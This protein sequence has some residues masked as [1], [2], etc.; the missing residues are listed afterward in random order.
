MRPVEVVWPASFPDA[1]PLIIELGSESSELA[2]FRFEDRSLCLFA[3][4]VHPR[5]W[6]PEL[7]VADALSRYVE[8]RARISSGELHPLD[9]PRPLPGHPAG[10][11]IRIPKALAR[12][13]RE[14][15]GW[16]L[17]RGVLR[18][19]RESL[20]VIALRH[21]GA[22][23]AP[24]IAHNSRPWLE[25]VGDGQPMDFAWCGIKR[26]DNEAWADLFQDRASLMALLERRCPPHIAAALRKSPFMILCNTKKKNDLII[27][28]AD[29]G[30][31]AFFGLFTSSIEVGDLSDRVFARV[32]GALSG[33]R[34]LSTA[35]VICVG[36]G[37]LG[38]PVAVQL[39]RA[40]V[41][42]FSLFDPERLSPENV[43]RHVGGLRDLDRPKVEVVRDA[44]LQRHAD[45][46]VHIHAS[47]LTWD[48]DDM[49]STGP[50]FREALADPGALVVVTC[51][52]E[53][54][55]RAV[56]RLCVEL[57]RPVVFG[58][59]LGAGRHGRVFRVLPGESPC[60]E[61][62]RRAQLAGALDS[63]EE[64]SAR[65]T[66]GHGLYG[67]P[68]LPGLGLDVDQVGLMVARMAL[69]TLARGRSGVDYPD[70]RGHHLTWSNHGGWHF[71]CPLQARVE[72]VARDAGC[73]VCGT[74]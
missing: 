22:P 40:G 9:W 65:D 30:F 37:S 56:N 44:I 45:A 74:G 33:R 10:F 47:G 49:R 54:V 16:G 25:Q 32:D 8:L 66:P 72:E 38:S 70:A 5:A 14:S 19:E 46:E 3:H 61:C 17:A 18:P 39:A 23:R 43:A 51:A 52:E 1:P 15:R 55:E 53:R 73:P 6:N 4:G 48:R 62:V 67:Q 31:T 42:R 34:T 7:G 36:L 35:H 28:Q 68:G 26:R 12:E 58:A 60:Y 29:L 27:I 63:Y 2:P 59:V 50:A 57:E 21:G 41:G 13:M 20:D 69:Q 71:D 11:R 64:A 24:L